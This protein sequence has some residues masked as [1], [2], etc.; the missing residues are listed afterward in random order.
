MDN[1]PPTSDWE[2]AK[3]DGKP[4][5]GID[6]IDQKGQVHKLGRSE[7]RFFRDLRGR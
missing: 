3:R 2:L 4:I 1:S 5:P 6:G 7:M